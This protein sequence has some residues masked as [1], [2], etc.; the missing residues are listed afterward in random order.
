[1][2]SLGLDLGFGFGGSS[3][4][5]TISPSLTMAT[6]AADRIY[7]RDIGETSKDVPLS[8]TY[9]VITPGAIEG[10]VLL[11]ADDSEV[12]AWTAVDASPSG[13]AWSGVLN[14]PQ[15]GPYYIEVRDDGETLLATSN[16]FFVGALIIGYGQSNWLGHM[17]VTSSP[18]AAEANTRH[19]NGS[20]WV[21]VPVGNGVREMLNFLATDTGIP[22][23][24]VSGGQ[25]G[26]L[27]S[28][29]RDGQTAFENLQTDIAAMGGDAEFVVY[30]QGEG[31]GDSGTSIATWD[32]SLDALH[33]ELC[34]LT[35]RTK[36]QMPLVVSSL[37]TMDDGS[38]DANWNDIQAKIREA[39]SDFANI[40]F[41]HSNMD[42]TRV[43]SF[44][45][46]AASYGRSGR[47]YA[48]TIADLLGTESTSPAWFVDDVA[49]IIDDVN[50][51]VTVT[52]S[53]GTDFTPTSGITGFECSDDNGA[54]WESAT[55][56]R[57]DATT[58]ELTHASLA[59]DAP[60]KV[61][62]QYGRQPDVSAPVLDNSSIA[63]PL[64][65]T[66]GQDISADELAGDPPVPT[67]IT[68]RRDPSFPTSTQHRFANVDI[69]PDVAGELIIVGWS[70]GANLALNSVDVVISGHSNPSVTIVGQTGAA[71]ARGGF[72][73]FV[74]P[75][76]TLAEITLNLAA[77]PFTDS[78][79]S[80]WRVPIADL[81]SQTAVDYDGLHSASATTLSRDLTTSADGFMLAVANN[82]SITGPAANSNITGDEAWAV[83]NEAID[84][85]S[86]HIAGDASGVAAGTNDNTVNVSFP[87]AAATVLVAASWR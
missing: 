43:D 42:A 77:N 11:A 19:F 17:T 13:N 14:V 81:N 8:G 79:I 34:A 38:T 1:M 72:F 76:G 39:D 2:T 45:W 41:S 71:N 85:G 56:A 15:G 59:T 82:R 49:E 48:Q 73:Q 47:R 86:H 35:G 30:H 78:N 4:D 87:N 61:R 40:H 7:Q 12:V 69:G 9:N 21:S 62:Y 32:T 52:H 83:R 6:I 60:R 80:L 57:V 25:N 37:S 55:G 84:A 64:C 63:S 31:E 68:V 44:H 75:G 58:I 67:Y 36:A 66:A 23:G 54:S 26:V 53:M 70:M 28:L 5:G 50:T 65:H 24:I 27:I 29:L 51:R 10:R 46:N 3:G 20:A 16:E 22:W 18:P 33:G 74:K